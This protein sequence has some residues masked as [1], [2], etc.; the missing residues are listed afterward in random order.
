MLKHGT[1]GDWDASAAIQPAVVKTKC[2]YEMWYVGAHD[3]TEPQTIG[4]A[5]SPDGIHW[6]K[7][8]HN[9]VLLLDAW[10]VGLL[11]PTVILQGNKYQMWYGAFLFD[12]DALRGAIGYAT[13]PR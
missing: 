11:F 6:I 9:P 7:Y 8:P 4:Y 10:N 2:G 13:M 12:G 1:S 3:Y 5:F